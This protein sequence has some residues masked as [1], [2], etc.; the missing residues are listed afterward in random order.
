MSWPL[1]QPEKLR[2]AELGDLQPAVVEHEV[3]RVEVEVLDAVLLIEV[4]EHLG[5]GAEVI[6]QLAA[7]DARLLAGLALPEAVAR[8]FRGSRRS[9]AAAG[10]VHVGE[11][12]RQQ[13]GVVR[14]E[15]SRWTASL[16]SAAS[17]PPQAE[18]E[19]QELLLAVRILDFPDFHQ[20]RCCR[21]NRGSDSRRSTPGGSARL[22][23]V[24]ANGAGRG[25]GVVNFDCGLGVVSRI[26]H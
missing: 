3:A 13:G 23:A 17:E 8:W 22:P 19:L 6:D 9:T 7:H 1:G 12:R 16:S 21:H 15:R 10:P 14:R 24:A 4:I 20:R 5:G 26:R 25:S 2:V 11:L 18:E